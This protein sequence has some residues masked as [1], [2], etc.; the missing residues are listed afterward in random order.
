M[1]NIV[2]ISPV[3]ILS[4]T[5]ILIAAVNFIFKKISNIWVCCQFG[6]GLIATC[7]SVFF[8]W[9]ENS[10]AFGE[11]YLADNFTIFIIIILL[12]NLGLCWLMAFNQY[13][14]AYIAYPEFS[15]IL[16]FATVGMILMVSSTNLLVVFLG[17]EILSI[18]LYF[19]IGIKKNT[20]AS[21]EAAVKYL[22]IGTFSSAFILYG[23]AFLFG[24]TGSL[25]LKEI[26]K[27]GFYFVG[28]NGFFTIGLLLVIMGLGLRIGLV[29]FHMWTSDIYKGAPV[30]VTAFM[31]SGVTTA[32]FAVLIRI[33]ASLPLGFSAQWVVTLSTIAILTILVGNLLAISQKNVKRMLTYSAL[34]QVGY[35]FVGLISKNNMGANSVVYYLLVF[36]FM[37]TG[38][39]AVLTFFSNQDKE[40][41]F[42][43]DFQGLVYKHPVIAFVMTGFIFSLAGL[44][45]F[46]GFIGRVFLLSSAVKSGHIFLVIF[47]ILGSLIALYFY[48]QFVV[49]MFMQEP[50]KGMPT[51]SKS[52]IIAVVLLIAAISSVSL[53]LFPAYFFSTVERFA[54]LQ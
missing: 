17:F 14:K 13:E 29:P 27:N 30:P 12:I 40:F 16:I 45:P 28:G 6:L 36:T 39:L 43:D 21:L 32:I 8:L 5:G 25:D 7:I 42:L 50:K 3:L 4:A 31:I 19:L 54:A 47:S 51:S 9:N 34:A 1:S 11:L 46:A 38:A 53:G 10:F 20:A 2:V 52:Q 44:P 18:C 15:A 35:I 22:L 48:F 41:I 49:V 23:M 33:S 24:A 37:N 26:F